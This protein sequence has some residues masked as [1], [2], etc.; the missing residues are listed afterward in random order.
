MHAGRDW[1]RA[2][3]RERRAI[4]YLSDSDDDEQSTASAKEKFTPK[5]VP[6]DLTGREKRQQR[7]EETFRRI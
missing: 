5:E 1:A 7:L 3:D 4:K 2:Q 6:K